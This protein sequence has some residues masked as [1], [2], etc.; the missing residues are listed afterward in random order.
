MNCDR[1][2]PG[3]QDNPA[4]R[5]VAGHRRRNGA[6]AVP[7]RRPID[8]SP[9]GSG[10]RP[11]EG[12]RIAS[13]GFP[14]SQAPRVGRFRRRCGCR[15]SLEGC[16]GLARAHRRGR[17]E[18][19]D[20]GAAGGFDDPEEEWNAAWRRHYQVNVQAPARLMRAAV[21]HFRT[22]GAGVIILMSSWVAQRGAASPKMLAYAASKP[23]SRRWRNPWP[24]PTRRKESTRTSSPPASSAPGCRWTSRNCRAA[25]RA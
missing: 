12:A 13:R 10:K 3:R 17:V 25:F 11:R 9:P 20:D 14:G 8:R 23:P 19:R 18:C 22:R 5:R 16:R 24:E 21:R 2:E 7:G 4:D 15:T 6:S 1:G